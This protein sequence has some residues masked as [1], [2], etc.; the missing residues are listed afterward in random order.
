MINA[1]GKITDLNLATEKVTGRSRTELIGTDFSDYFTEP[2]QARDVYMQVFL[3]RFVTDYPLALLHR[4]GHVTDVLYNA[5][6]YC[7]EAGEV[8]GVF[9]AARDITA[10]K[11]AEAE[12]AHINRALSTVSAVNRHL[13]YATDEN[14]LLQTICQAIVERHGYRMAWVGYVQQDEAKSVKIIARAGDDDGYLDT[15][16]ITWGE[17]ERGMGPTGRAIRSGVTQLCQDIAHD[18]RNLPWRDAALKNGYAAS[19]SLPLADSNGKIF[20][21][22]TVYAE[23]ANAF[24]PPEIDLLEEMAGDLAFGVRMLHVR[25]ERDLALKQSQQYFDQLQAGFEDTVRA[26]AGI[27]EL[28]D[29]YTAGHQVRVAGLAAAI[30]RQMNLS[31]DS[32]KMIHLASAVH[33]LGKIKIPAEILSKPGRLS[34]IEY[35]LIKTH[36]QAGYEILKDIHFQYPISR[37]VQQHHEHLD[38]SGYPQGLKG[39]E[40][41]LEARILS[42]ADVVEAISSHRPYR[43]AMGVDAALEEITLHRGIYFDPEVVDA[44]ITLFKDKGYVF[45]A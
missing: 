29:P 36:A 8:L 1:E 32:V 28:R 19:I 15:L 24:S 40:I 31:E 18:P 33:D 7:N 3:Q 26:I 13:V 12:T 34:P 5:S 10:R 37:I 41:L 44:C 6:V 35:E 27:V 22:L 9:A 21:T 23:E 11:Q 42:V 43:P 4:D 16:R 17:S 38:G 20:G 45:T 39:D 14:Q 25:K 2:K 30:A